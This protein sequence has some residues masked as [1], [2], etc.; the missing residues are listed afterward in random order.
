[1]CAI[2]LPPS[3]RCSAFLQGKG[4]LCWH[5]SVLCTHSQDK[6]WTDMKSWPEKV[7][8][9]RANDITFRSL[10]LETFW[11][12]G[13]FFLLHVERDKSSQVYS[14]DKR[15]CPGWIQTGGREGFRK[16]GDEKYQMC[17]NC[18]LQAY[19]Q[20]DAKI[21]SA[22][23]SYRE[24]KKWGGNNEKYGLRSLYIPE[25]IFIHIFTRIH[26]WRLKLIVI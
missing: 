22:G 17:M 20:R 11:I 26:L 2:S 10:F 23:M 6:Q 9:S 25:G 4:C 16:T 3:L 8:S 7:K 13:F 1:M 24:G 15:L 12:M 5:A 19:F 18:C 14:R 21:I